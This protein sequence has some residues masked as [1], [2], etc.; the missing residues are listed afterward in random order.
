MEDRQLVWRQLLAHERSC[1]KAVADLSP[2]SIPTSEQ[3]AALQQWWASIE[4]VLRAHIEALAQ[5]FSL[6]PDPLEVLTIMKGMAGYIAV[7]KIPD[8]IADAA[9]EGRTS[10]GPTE[11]RDIGFA[12]AYLI[13][14][15]KD[16]GGFEHQGEKIKIHD[17]FPVKTVSNAFGVHRATVYGWGKTITPENL[18]LNRLD[19]TSLTGL[20]VMAGERYR[21]A[22]R[23]SEAILTRHRQ[24]N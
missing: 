7:G 10:A 14:A 18:G 9:A 11:R 21:A 20:M 16:G 8:P 2:D 12:V 1:R 15:K 5:G 6:R 3:K 19:A 22:G 23:S 13:A 4:G 17:K 24:R